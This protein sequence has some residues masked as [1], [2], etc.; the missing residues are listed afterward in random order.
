MEP[1]V[2]A[3]LERW[4][5]Y[6]AGGGRLSIEV[7][8][9]SHGEVFTGFGAPGVPAQGVAGAVAD[10]AR[11]YLAG[12]QPVSQ[13]LADQLLIATAMS[14]GGAFR[15]GRPPPH[16]RTNQEIVNRFLPGSLECTNVAPGVWEF[17][18]SV[19]SPAPAT[20]TLGG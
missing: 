16:A 5:F 18:G 7:V 17:R 2:R 13:H 15:T 11:E 4:G 19:T 6:P 8:M 20:P 3:R 1:K 9:R 14:G 12:G 10:E